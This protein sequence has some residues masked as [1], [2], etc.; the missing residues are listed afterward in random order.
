MLL[1]ISED[2]VRG[3]SIIFLRHSIVRVL[4]CFG[5]LLDL[6]VEDSALSSGSLSSRLHLTR[7]SFT[8]GTMRHGQFGSVHRRKVGIAL[9]KG[10][11]DNVKIV[12]EVLDDRRA[13]RRE[14]EPRVLDDVFPEDRQ[15][16]PQR[17]WD[18]SLGKVPVSVS[19]LSVLL[20]HEDVER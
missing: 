3:R 20:H 11:Q 1:L 13:S 2:I 8:I 12:G 5:K 19:E 15:Q 17:A 18:F 14:R 7:K 9:L 6:P 4:S 16:A 10:A